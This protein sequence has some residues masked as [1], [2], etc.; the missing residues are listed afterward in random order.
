MNLKT[1]VDGER[2]RSVRLAR[3]LGVTP[4]VVSDWCN[5]KK[6]VPLARCGAIER[7]TG[8]AVTRQDLCP[9]Q[10]HHHWPELVSQQAAGGVPA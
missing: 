1:W 9:D 10:W 5:G 2:G 8:G 7:I 3:A 4:P 6:A